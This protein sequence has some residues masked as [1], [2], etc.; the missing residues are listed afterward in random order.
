MALNLRQKSNLIFIEI[1]FLGSV[2]TSL[3]LLILYKIY[4]FVFAFIGRAVLQNAEL[5]CGCQITPTQNNYFLLGFLSLLAVA[6]GSV[7]IIGVLKIILSVFKTNKFI[8]LE[9]NKKQSLS[10]KLAQIAR[11]TNL[12]KNI[13]Q[14]DSAKPII[15]CHGLWR[16]HIYVSSTIVQNLGF[17]ELKAAILHESHHLQTREPARLLAV[18]FISTFS[19]IPGIKNLTQKYLSFSEIAADEL[20]T[21]NF[22]TKQHLAS[23]MAKVLDLE[24][25]R[26]LQ[27]GLNLS[28]F[29]QIT[30]ERILALSNKKFQPTFVR[31]ALRAIPGLTI[32]IMILLLLPPQLTPP[33][34]STSLLPNGKCQDIVLVEKCQKNSNSEIIK[35]FQS[36]Q[37][38]SRIETGG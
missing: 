34:N 13:T 33:P 20:A 18:R 10:P 31:E 16:S 19:F 38:Q 7:L 30:E 2:L 37:N 17:S 6:I 21:N 3:F 23:A 22:Q 29:S 5:V 36:L 9:K 15:F 4:N 12:E 35:Y 25:R 1:I 14:I 32:I 11:Q 8:G 24:E 26:I 28:Y 27:T